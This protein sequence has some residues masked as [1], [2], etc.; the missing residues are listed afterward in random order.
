MKTAYRNINLIQRKVGK[1]GAVPKKAG[2]TVYQNPLRRKTG[3]GN[4]SPR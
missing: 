1:N 3:V 4:N 2:K